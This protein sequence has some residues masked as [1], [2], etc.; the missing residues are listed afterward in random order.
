M[1]IAESIWQDIQ[2]LVNRNTEEYRARS[3]TNVHCMDVSLQALRG[4]D[5]SLTPSTRDKLHRLFRK[6]FF[7]SNS[8]EEAII[9]AKNED[10]IDRSL[11]VEDPVWGDYIVGPSYASLQRRVAKVLKSS[12]IESLFTGTDE[13]GYTTTNIGHLSLKESAQ[14]TTP[15]ETKLQTLLQAVSSSPIA[16]QFINRNINKL[17]K[18]HR[19]DTSYVFN[20]KSFELDKFSEILGSGTVLVV[21][22]TSAKNLAL[23]KIEAAIERD[24]RNYLTSDKF[25]SKI[26]NAKGS[27]SILEDI[28]GSIVAKLSGK[29]S[30][31]GSK[32]SKKPVKRASSPML[33]D[34][35][36]T[37]NRLPPLRNLGGQF[38]SLVKLQNII[39][40]QLARTIAN[41]MGDGT[42]KTILNYRT[43]RLANSAK[44]ERMSQSREGMVT[45]FY[46]YM[47]NPYGTFSEGG[48]QGIPR[49]RDPKLLISKS[50][51]EIA[52]TQVSNRMRA[53]LA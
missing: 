28:V 11:F 8:L 35:K 21:L 41:N 37:L 13:R 24:V 3:D 16:A 44:V 46:T 53:V 52:A 20:R 39:N 18:Q 48:A 30:V 4:S 49:S 7:T 34:R 40:E 15:L 25:K 33:T 22:Q 6:E 50:I 27:N 47:R 10:N 1:G 32:H 38:T 2:D 19:A 26:L 51:R 23:A 36:T 43:G 9:H 42:S 5:P 31:P 29:S 14:A 45:A 12:T 17:H